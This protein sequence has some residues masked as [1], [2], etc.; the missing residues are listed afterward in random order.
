MHVVPFDSKLTTLFTFYD[1]SMLNVV[2]NRA[3]TDP[4][5]PLPDYTTILPFL[6]ILAMA[7]PSWRVSTRN[8][9]HA[10]Y[11]T[12]EIENLLERLCLFKVLPQAF[13]QG[14][15]GNP[16]LR[17]SKKRSVEALSAVPWSNLLCFVFS[18]G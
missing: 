13:S 16:M 18:K 17:S 10:G 14:V 12:I 4:Y 15:G 5:K 1:A 11:V 7:V 8:S 9:F 3:Y 2:P 6:L